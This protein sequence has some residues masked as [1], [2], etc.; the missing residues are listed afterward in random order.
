LGRL[1]TL[2]KAVDLEENAPTT[3]GSFCDEPAP[4]A[5]MMEAS[6]TIPKTFNNA[7]FISSFLF[8]LAN[9]Q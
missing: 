2:D 9:H 7:F 6:T 8:E 3:S 5:V 4:Q 1:L